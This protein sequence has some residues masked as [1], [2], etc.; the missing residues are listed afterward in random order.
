MSQTSKGSALSKKKS[1]FP[2]FRVA[3]HPRQ[4]EVARSKA[5][6]RVLVAGRRF[7]KTY[8][9]L[10]EMLLAARKPGSLVWY[11]GPNDHQ[12][13]RIAWE[14]LKKSSP[15]PTG[16]AAPTKRSF[17]SISTGILPL[18]SVAASIPIHSVAMAS[19]SSFS[20]SSPPIARA[21]GPKSFALLSV[22]AKGALSSSAHRKGA[23]ISMI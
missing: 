2:E 6:F 14:R 11:V 19:I 5:R 4:D 20:M 22:I 21:L 23:T 10:T 16:W 9:A 17:A 12:A 15:G 18:W 8:L 1:A 3:L 7:G 13:K